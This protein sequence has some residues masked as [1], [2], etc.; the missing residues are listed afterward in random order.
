MRP[1]RRS[2]ASLHLGLALIPALAACGDTTNKHTFN[3]A[4]VTQDSPAQPDAPLLDA[5][6]DAA[7]AP[8]PVQITVWDQYGTLE[9][10]APVAFVDADG[11]LVADAV[12]DANGVA[13]A[14][15]HPGA[16]VT[17]IRWADGP[18]DLYTF[19]GVKPGDHL[20]LGPPPAQTPL[21][22]VTVNFPPVTGAANYN[23]QTA[24]GSVGVVANQGSGAPTPTATLN[25]YCNATKGLMVEALDG[26]GA[27]LGVIL[28]LDQPLTGTVDLTAMSYT[29][30]GSLDV[31]VNNIPA[32]VT[33]I[34]DSQAL[35]T[36]EAGIVATA[37]SSIS[38]SGVTATETLALPT[39]TTGLWSTLQ[40]YRPG[41]SQAIER[42][43]P[44][45]GSATFDLG[46]NL[47]PWLPS[48]GV[49]DSVTR[50]VRWTELGVGA[51][52][53]T[54]TR[55]YVGIPNVS[56]WY[57]VAPYTSQ[58]LDLPTLPA[59]FATL[60]PAPTI[61]V[62]VNG[63]ALFKLP[64]GAWDTIRA[65]AFDG[66]TDLQIATKGGTPTATLTVSS[67]GTW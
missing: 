30:R 49:Y 47:I 21:V 38:P 59:G 60:D 17:T 19:E 54:R 1:L 7:P 41:A 67:F 36:T 18:G 20:L 4:G 63:I 16:T 44:L 45:A 25:T 24:C 42:L 56:Y 28:Q 51:A 55:L 13:T 43:A 12:T 11:T 3:D 48:Q 27:S 2:S 53:V 6:P 22:S 46:A 34:G 9:N 26:A 31:T 37:S 29:P 50:S 61:N 40:V 62:T 65:L 8:G 14:T 23:V 64:P 39:A 52:T 10:G 35:L 32:F 66:P 58:R 15:V 33:S 5:A 57:V